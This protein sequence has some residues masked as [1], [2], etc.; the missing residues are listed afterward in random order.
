MAVQPFYL[1]L[2]LGTWYELASI[3]QI[4][5]LGC[6]R[7]VAEYSLNADRTVAV[8]NWCTLKKCQFPEE[9][10]PIRS[11]RGVARQIS[12]GQGAFEV[13]F[14]N[15]PYWK[16]EANYKVLYVEYNKVALV[17]G[18]S[19]S[20]LWILA[21]NPNPNDIDYWGLMEIAASQGYETS[22]VRMHA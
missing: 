14:T 3:P 16:G 5:A 11:T 6:V 15:P 22:R 9:P 21:R 2:Y 10:C 17:G 12:P 13:S 7:Q 8:H 19:P 20:S 18:S 4:F 1:E